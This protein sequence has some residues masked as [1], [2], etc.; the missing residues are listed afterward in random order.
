MNNPENMTAAERRV[1]LSLGR[2]SDRIGR[3]PV[4]LGGLMLSIGSAWGALSYPLPLQHG[5]AYDIQ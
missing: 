5:A 3:K 1:A 4:I 2:L